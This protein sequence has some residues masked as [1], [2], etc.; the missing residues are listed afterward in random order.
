MNCLKS[1][2]RSN[3]EMA[4]RLGVSEKAIR[5]LLRPL[6]AASD[7]DIV[8]IRLSQLS[9]PTP[10]VGRLLAGGPALGTGRFLRPMSPDSSTNQTIFASTGS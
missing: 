7:A 6:G 5:K 3:L 2:G 4:R 8:R 10:A 1:L 9:L